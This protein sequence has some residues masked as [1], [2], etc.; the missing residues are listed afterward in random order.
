MVQDQLVEYISAQFKLGVSRDAVK[1]ALTGVGWAPLDIEDTLRK[2]EGGA[3]VPAQSPIMSGSMASPRVVSFSAPGTVAGQSKNPEPQTIRVSDMVSSV[4]PSATMPSSMAAPKIIS[5]T[6]DAAKTPAKNSF[7][8]SPSATFVATSSGK[9]KP[10]GM[11]LSILAVVLIVL[12]GG[13]AGYLFVQNNGLQSQLQSAQSGQQGQGAAQTQLSAAQQQVQTLTASNTTLTAQV[14]SL[15]AANQDLTT[16]LS[17]FTVPANSPSLATSSPVSVSGILAAG[18]GK[19]TY[20]ITTT[21]G[22]KAYVKTPRSRPSP[23]RS[24][25]FSAR[26]SNLREPIFP[27]HRT[28]SSKA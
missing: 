21:Y 10:M 17:F 13:F 1:S 20:M 4:S 7:I 18:L 2:V 16:N 28:S 22:V 19:N 24:S 23:P 5:G 15:T 27:E 11:I 8:S 9:K 12:L 25:R 26:M 6:M 14:A 3:A